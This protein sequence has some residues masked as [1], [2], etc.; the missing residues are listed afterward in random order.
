MKKLSRV[1]NDKFNDKVDSMTLPEIKK[2][3]IIVQLI[4]IVVIIVA[5]ILVA[6]MIQYF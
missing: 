4:N 5:V 1:L 2:S 3:L 6:M